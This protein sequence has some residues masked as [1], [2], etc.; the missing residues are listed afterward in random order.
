M[1]YCKDYPL[2]ND[3]PAV[4]MLLVYQCEDSFGKG[5][6]IFLKCC[7]GCLKKKKSYQYDFELLPLEK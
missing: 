7:V 4:F 6:F 2:G 3:K 1:K 5:F